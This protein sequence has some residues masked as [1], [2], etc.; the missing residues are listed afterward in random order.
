MLDEYNDKYYLKLAERGK[1]FKQDN[2]SKARELAD[3]KEHLRSGWDDIEVLS[4][5]LPDHSKDPLKLGN[6]FRAEVHLNSNSIEPKD[7]GVE[8][9][10]TRKMDDKQ[11][12]ALIIKPLKL[13]R[14]NKD[15]SVY[16]CEFPVEHSGLLDF[17]FRMYP[18]HPLLPHRQDF[19]LT[20][21]I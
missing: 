6:T 8:I 5:G 10:F 9:V 2:C 13:I 21:W 11:K 12:K 15:S 7:I 14:N 17:A 1:Y 4:I 18:V 20:K 16:R 19:N 3:W